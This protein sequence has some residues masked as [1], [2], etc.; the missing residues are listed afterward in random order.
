MWIEV[1][2]VG[3]GTLRD[4]YR[5]DVPSALPFSTPSWPKHPETGRP[6]VKTVFICVPDA[7][8]VPPS[9]KQIVRNDIL[10][11]LPKRGAIDVKNIL[12]VEQSWRRP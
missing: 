1:S 6:L 7:A 2:L 4:P 3:S 12:H 9:A 10:L 11:E 8:A 5:P